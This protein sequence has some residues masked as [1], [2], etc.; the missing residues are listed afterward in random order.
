M[1]SSLTAHM[2][3]KNEDR[4]VWFAINSVLPYVDAMLITDTGSTDKTVEI[5]NSITSPKIIFTQ[6][7]TRTREDITRARQSQIDATKTKWFWIVDGDEIYTDQC[8]KEVVKAINVEHNSAV[9]V[10]RLDLLGD[11]Y[12]QQAE[13][14]GAYE[15]FG[16]TGHLLIRLLNKDLLSDLS[17]KGKYPQE[18]YYYKDDK[19]VNDLGRGDVYLTKH[20]LYHAMYLRR[21]G[22][23]RNL[24]MFNRGKYKIET[25][26][27]IKGEYPSVFSKPRPQFVPD[28]F[29]V[30]GLSYELLA[31]LITPIKQ[32]KRK[33]I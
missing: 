1:N 5:I 24:T 3:V 21:S 11:I 10:R 27:K 31:R 30:R 26:L 16:E 4:W 33:L 15:M 9:V 28:P 14:I 20:A 25:G 29:A 2:V 17:V 22:L 8:A 23:G 12:H 13:S 6:I 32:L 19:C 7:H 18:S